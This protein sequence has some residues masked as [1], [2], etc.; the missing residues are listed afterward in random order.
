MPDGVA[1][2]YFFQ[3]NAAAYTPDWVNLCAIEPECLWSV[4][5][6]QPYRRSVSEG[7]V[8]S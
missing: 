4:R 3:R 1:G 8:Y 5:R 2:K 7:R 6:R